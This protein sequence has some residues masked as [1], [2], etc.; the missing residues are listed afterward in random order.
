MKLIQ[1]LIKY[2]YISSIIVILSII[3]ISK[4][5]AE[6]SKTL[7]INCD[8]DKL[9]N[10]NCTFDINAMIWKE[11]KPWEVSSLNDPKQFLQ[12]IFF[13]STMFITV[14]ASLWLIYSGYNYIMAWGVDAK[15]LDEAQKWIKYSLIWVLIVI[16]SVVI[17][18]VI[19]FI[20]A[21]RSLWF[22]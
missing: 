2:I 22:S 18:R 8:G 7:G 1:K 17:V 20:A 9:V 16:F 3:V 14:L 13:T 6:P 10:W 15:K 21:W 12:D 19:Q 4:T 11:I 5:N